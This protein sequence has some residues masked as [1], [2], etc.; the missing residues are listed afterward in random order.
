MH[1][2]QIKADDCLLNFAEHFLNPPFFPSFKKGF[3]IL[4]GDQMR[5]IYKRIPKLAA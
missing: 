4:V 1:L 5:A 2:S 3:E